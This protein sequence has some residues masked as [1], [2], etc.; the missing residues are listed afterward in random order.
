M[1]KFH[2]VKSGDT[3]WGISKN[4]HMTV[5][6]LAKINSLSGNMIHNL[7]IGQKIY[8]E[9]ILAKI[10]F[11]TNL[12]IILMDLSFK[13]ILKAS[14]KLEYDGKEFFRNTKNGVFDN[15]GIEDHSKGIKVFLKNINGSFDLIANH[16]NLPLGRKVLKLTSRKIKVEGKHYAKDG[17]FQEKISEIKNGLKKIGKPIVDAASSVL[18]NDSKYAKSTPKDQVKI[19]EERKEQKRTDQGNSTHIIASQFTEDNFL[20]KPVNNKYRKYIVNAAK[21]HGFT[22]HALAAFIDAEAA[23]IRKTGE[24][25][26]NSKANSSS[27]AGLTQFLD[28]TWLAMCDDNSS[29]VGQYV[30]KNPNISKYKKLN[31][32]FNAEFA[33]DAA[34][35]YAVKNF[36][37]SGL[38]Y[39]NLTEPSSMAKLAYLL[40]HE[41]S[42]G[43]TN[44][45]LN[46]LSQERAKKLLFTQF[47]KNGADQASQFLKRYK[48]DAKSAYGAWLRNY[49]DG[50]INIYQYVV[51]KR[52]TSGINLS[53][54]ETIKLLN[55]KTISKPVPKAQIDQEKASHKQNS[56]SNTPKV[57]TSNTIQNSL[58]HTS[59]IA[60]GENGWHNPLLECKLRTA[61]LAN[62]RG[63][64]FGKV[65]NN[66]TRNHQG[67]DLQANPGTNIYAVCS[68]IIVSAMNT[69]GA[70]GKVIV[71]KV[72]I[73]DLPEKQ[74]KY[75]KS[76]LSNSYV[77]FFY[78]HLSTINVENKDIV[79]M[80]E[81]IGKTGS[82][83]N[84]SAMTTIP[85]GAHL[86][87]EARSAPL[88][89]VG[90]TGRMDPIPFM[91]A[92][93][94]Y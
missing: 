85:K 62:A 2:I 53:M 1:S 71:L 20:L 68:G 18:T 81:I 89:G 47:G 90:L 12:K 9:E 61:G 64:T 42:T 8:L 26:V 66:G 48:N 30:N 49:I 43:G 63:A 45:V 19:P 87:F 40:H 72:D 75:A 13:P 27:A 92:N 59:K 21:R 16:K 41:G 51:D 7:K 50:H 39:K 37:A 93:L 35:A 58:E 52:K 6:E 69:G 15:I 84:A 25:N 23:K 73:N 77:Y 38:P 17:V 28:Q 55:G 60:G 79:S 33:I 91:N 10:E 3:L 88:L 74:K 78:A 31:L 54:D 22:P 76:K 46:T 34:A 32:R 4:N 29:L 83:G 36:K 56:N 14:I 11:E 70:Y 94:P 65:R 5:K 24:W 44:F 57:S 86:H 80:G 82:T 67:V